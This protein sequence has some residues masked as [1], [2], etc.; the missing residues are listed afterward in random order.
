MATPSLDEVASFLNMIEDLD[1]GATQEAIRE[2]LG[3]EE[4]AVSYI[5]A[6]VVGSGYV[7]G[8]VFPDA[9]GMRTRFYLTALGHDFLVFLNRFVTATK[10]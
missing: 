8:V 7:G 1:S 3:W 4:R 6:A 10:M 2:R 9:S 5:L